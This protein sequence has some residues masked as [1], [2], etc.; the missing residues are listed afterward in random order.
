MSKVEIL[1]SLF[2]G[3]CDDRNERLSQRTKWG[4]YG[5]R[6]KN[7]RSIFNRVCRVSGD[8]CGLT[9][10]SSETILF[11]LLSSGGR[12]RCTVVSGFSE[13]LTVGVRIDGPVTK[14]ELKGDHVLPISLNWKHFQL[15]QSDLSLSVSL[16]LPL[17]PSPSLPPSLSAPSL[18]PNMIVNDPFLRDRLSISWWRDHSLGVFSNEWL[19]GMSFRRTGFMSDRAEPNRQVCW[20]VQ[21]ICNEIPSGAASEIALL[22]PVKFEGELSKF[23]VIDT[24]DEARLQSERFPRWKMWRFSCGAHA[25]TPSVEIA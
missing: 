7:S 9:L 13:L 5:A 23:T 22:H 2:R 20:H 14:K 25:S 17:S 11:R 8:V 19:I 10:L 1:F 16:S 21:L 15:I 18:P 24:R 6:D 3:R 12:W 4:G